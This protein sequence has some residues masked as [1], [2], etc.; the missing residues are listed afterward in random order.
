[1]K[2][3]SA[4]L[5]RDLAGAQGLALAG[6]YQEPSRQRVGEKLY[7]DLSHPAFSQPFIPPEL[8]KV[9]DESGL[10]PSTQWPWKS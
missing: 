7:L 10:L 8:G 9:K 1:M 2:F 4:V 5:P 6:S 3:P